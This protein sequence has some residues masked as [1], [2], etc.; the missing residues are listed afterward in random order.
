MDIPSHLKD[1]HY[2]DAKK[3]GRGIDYKYPHSYPNNYVEQQYLPDN[4]K[5]KVYYIPQNNKFERN[6]EN[7]IKTLKK[8]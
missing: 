2:K 4:L 8:G 6:I 5:D 3:I 7:F 1:S